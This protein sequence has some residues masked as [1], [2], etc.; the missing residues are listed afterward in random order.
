M[1]A[2]SALKSKSK[3]KIGPAYLYIIMHVN[4]LMVNFNCEFGDC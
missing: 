3:T 4:S 2:L 1:R